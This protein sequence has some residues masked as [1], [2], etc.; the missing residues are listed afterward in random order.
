MVINFRF[1]LLAIAA[2]IRGSIIT[3]SIAVVLVLN[4]CGVQIRYSLNE[5]ETP[6]SKQPI[7]MKVQVAEFTDLRNSIEKDKDERDKTGQ[8]DLS[9]YTYDTEFQGTVAEEIT[10]M[11]VDHLN[12]SKAF[13]NA[14]KV[15]ALSSQD[16]SDTKLD[17]LYISGV[18]GVLTGDVIHFY[19]YYDQSLGRKILYAVP[20]GVA[21]GLL[22]NWTFTTAEG[23]YMVYWYGPGL[24]LGYYLESLHSRHIEYQTLLHTKLI[25]TSTHQIIWEEDFDVSFSGEKKIPGINTEQRKFEVAIIS[26]RDAVNKMIADLSKNSDVIMQR[27]DQ[28]SVQMEQRERP[29]IIPS[30]Q[31]KSPI[32]TMIREKGFRLGIVGG[33]N[34]AS[35]SGYENGESKA[36]TG[37]S[38]GGRLSYRFSDALAIRMEIAYST[39]GSKFKYEYESTF[40]LP[41]YS[42]Q[43]YSTIIN[44]TTNLSYCEKS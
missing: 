5:E 17:A 31:Q 29:P 13:S 42:N 20:L 11:L 19:G 7:P 43:A 44:G 14:I 15:E 26:L 2:T 21:S 28:S 24:W 23:Q 12:F 6:K 30:I 35:I 37:F 22:L 34:I 8:S 27:K 25:S 32:A 36:L 33:V 1:F 9:D 18:E 38:V 41:P 40:F 3:F 10:Q 4:G 16:I 39:K